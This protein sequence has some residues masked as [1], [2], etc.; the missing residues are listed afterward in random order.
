MLFRRHFVNSTNPHNGQ[1]IRS[2]TAHNGQYIEETL[3]AAQNRFE[4]WKDVPVAEKSKLLHAMAQ[5]LRRNKHELALLMADEMGKP[6]AEGEG[7]IE[8]CATACE[9]YADEGP[10]Y[11]SP[12]I[13]KTDASK[14]WISYEPLGPV[15][16][17]MPWNF[18]F[19]QVI[20]FAAP[21]LLAGNVG[22]LKHASNVSGCSLAIESLFLQAG[23]PKHVFSSLLVSGKDV[24]AIIAHPVIKAV[25]IT[26]STPA[27]KS[28]ASTAGKYLK[29]CVLELGGSDAYVVLAD[30][31][32]KKAAQIC[33]QSRLLNGGQSCIAAKRFIVDKKV[34]KEFE[35]EMLEAFK[36]VKWGDPR[37]PQ[38]TMGPQARVDLRDQLHEQVLK[39][40]KLGAEILFGGTVDTKS[41]GAYYPP[42]ILT[43]VKPGLPAFD[44]ELFGPVAAIIEAED[45]NDAIRLA[46]QSVFG[47][48]AALFTKDI[49]KAER[50]ASQVQAGSV[51]INA[52]VKSDARLPFGGIKESG[53][54]RELSY[55][56]LRE[57]LNIKTIYR[58]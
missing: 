51:F 44:E 26:G 58:A 14:S 20:R 48:G 22:I 3:K 36:K 49:S 56:G 31:D 10:Q 52:L 45:E 18:P 23:F 25:T 5:Q 4:T 38:N 19:W 30:A 8:K 6:V 53:H 9:Y 17:V 7:E 37:D 15:L 57:F 11:L 39:S 28:V 16:A 24:E 32:I 29:K 21:N 33:T 46:N 27:G 55:Y 13:V 41:P 50:L 40:V 35:H 12:E 42:T 2:Y 1:V 34:R 43:Q 47:L 54:G